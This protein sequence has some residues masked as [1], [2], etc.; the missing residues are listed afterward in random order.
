MQEI[1]ERIT[2]FVRDNPVATN[3]VSIYDVSGNGRWTLLVSREHTTR[4]IELFLTAEHAILSN[5][6]VE[7]TGKRYIVTVPYTMGLVRSGVYT[8]NPEID[9]LE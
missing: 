3:E 6:T 8:Y 9:V 2:T 4:A 7:H 5:I 1:L